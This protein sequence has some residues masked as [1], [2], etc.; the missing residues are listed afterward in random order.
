MAFRASALRPLKSLA[1]AG[2]LLLTSCPGGGGGGAGPG[3]GPP[4]AP[5]ISLHGWYIT[6]ATQRLDRSVPLVAG[7]DGVL[8][9][10]LRASGANTATPEVRVTLTGGSPP[11]AWVRTLT[12][13]G[14]GVPTEVRE[15]DLGRSWNLSIPRALLVPGATIRLEVDPGGAVPG[16]DPAS[17]VVAAPLTVREIPPVY[18]KLIPVRQPDGSV[19]E[20]VGGGRTLDTWT[21][22]FR[23]MFPVAEVHTELGRELA[24][25]GNLSAPGDAAWLRL[26]AQLENRR[27]N[28]DCEPGKYYFGVVR[29]SHRRGGHN[30]LHGLSHLA[31]GESAGWDDLAAYQDTFAHEMGHSFGRAHAPCGVPGADADLDP[32]WPRDPQHQ[33]AALGA[34]GLDVAA[35]AA[36]APAI[37]T[38]PDYQDLMSYCPPYWISDYVYLRVM[39]HLATHPLGPDIQVPITWSAALR[40]PWPRLQHSCPGMP[41]CSP[42]MR[43]TL[44]VEAPHGVDAGVAPSAANPLDG[45]AGPGTGPGRGRGAQDRRRRGVP[46]P[47]RLPGQ[48]LCGKR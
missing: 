44:A 19:G 35:M 32:L 11:T 45:P 17:K 20:V 18:I 15:D 33:D 43:H 41:L 31:S 34:V 2:L 9:V 46:G 28:V 26:L 16:I 5:S 47:A 14:P 42:A 6:Q 12:A 48:P 21:D 27:K 29:L 7:R 22:H 8:R 23:R 37:R 38:S 3:G 10:F 25:P 13:P 1:L 40:G 4:A 36:G 30:H 39:I 24:T